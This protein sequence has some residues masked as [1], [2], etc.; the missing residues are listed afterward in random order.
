MIDTQSPQFDLAQR[1]A[2]RFGELP[3]VEAVALTGSASMGVADAHSDIDL[4]VYLR[5]DIAVAERIA[6]AS[7]VYRRRCRIQ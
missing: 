3:Q 1:L 5:A 2:T 6:V 4:Y 7:P